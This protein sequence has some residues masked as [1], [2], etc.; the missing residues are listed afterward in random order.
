[1]AETHT[2]SICE[3][4]VSGNLIEYLAHIEICIELN[5]Q[6][7]SSARISHLRVVQANMVQLPFAMQLVDFKTSPAM[8][9]S[10]NKHSP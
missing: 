3:Q 5:E 4:G 7:S 8:F 10:I 9:P 1:M 6:T 2:L